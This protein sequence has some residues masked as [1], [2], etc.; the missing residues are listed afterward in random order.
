MRAAVIRS[1]RRIRTHRPWHRF[2]ATLAAM[3]Q[4][5]ASNNIAIGSAALDLNSHEHI[6]TDAANREKSS[7]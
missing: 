7:T 6:M 5:H 2:I 3:Q 4:N 1:E